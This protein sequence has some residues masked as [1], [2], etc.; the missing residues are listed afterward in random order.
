[1]NG[2]LFFLLLYAYADLNAF[3]L[4]TG[5]ERLFGKPYVLLLH[6]DCFRLRR[7][8]LDIQ[9]QRRKFNRSFVL[10]VIE[11]RLLGYKRLRLFF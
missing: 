9:L 7:S 2:M 5:N 8:F 3:G 4:G 10:V 11:F 6:L 1:M